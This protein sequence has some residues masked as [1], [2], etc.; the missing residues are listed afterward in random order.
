MI[1]E[2]RPS[3]ASCTGLEQEIGEPVQEILAV[4]VIPKNLSAFNSAD[5]NV[6]KGAGGIY[7]SFSRHG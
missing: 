1:G 5:D 6:V 3:K 4:C 2:K 7:S